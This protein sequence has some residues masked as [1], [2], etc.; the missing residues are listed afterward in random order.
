MDYKEEIAMALKKATGLGLDF[1][2]LIEVPP[3]SAMGDYA[4][5][6]F[7]LAKELKKAPQ[8]V[9]A[10][11][12]AKMKESW[13]EKAEAK[14]P[15]LNFFIQK[16][17]LFE[18]VLSRI[19]TLKD[20]YGSSQEG[21]GKNALV[22]HTSINPN[23][24]PHVGRARNALI[25]DSIVRILRFQGYKTEVHYFV[26]DVGKQI[27]MLVY[28]AGK[29]KV[30]FDGLLQLYVDVNNKV[31]A[32]PGL[33]KK[34]FALLNK[35]ETG[36]KAVKQKFKAIVG[37]CIKGQ[38]KILGE[39][40]IK[41]D[42]F[43][44]ESKY[45]WNKRTEEVLAL[46]RAKGK[47]SEDEAGRLVLNQEEYNLPTKA[48]F[49]VLTRADKTSLY[50]LRDIAY[51]ID[52]AAKAKG[53]NIVVLGED[54]KLYFQQID[55]A[56]ALLGFRAPEAVH[57][58]FVLLS[59]GKMS[60]RQGNVILLEDFM[61]EAVEKANE[62]IKKRR[63]TSDLKTAKIVAY[64]AV[65]YAIL[66]VSNEKNVLF[67]WDSAL[68]FE[69][70]TGPYIQYTY[71]RARSILRKAKKMPSRADYCLLTA[72]SEKR[73]ISALAS[74]PDAVKEA[75]DHYRP[76]VVAKHLLDI[77]QA[78]N[79]FYHS[80]QCLSDCVDPKLRD[81]RLMLVSSASLALKNGLFLIGISAPEKM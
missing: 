21:R 81:A 7:S 20:K 48:P 38:A 42:S 12:Q 72:D 24:S 47:L 33:E 60:T 28:G 46:L 36:D 54:Q 41:Y 11:L 65:K 63:G 62:E 15:Y 43:D 26:N 35:L 78:F 67:D 34:V 32:N 59:D 5:P 14:G 69:G 45:L 52:K 74:F 50:P 51:T 27:A 4:L 71:A 22:E 73:L 19:Q 61:K 70:E 16:S 13:I 75:A 31:K 80:C 64:G 53:K 56:L 1:L 39:L 10:E 29:K 40:G 55:A 77:S 37:T 2:Q 79:E 58:S 25:G 17:C 66:K 68:N 76:S 6:C 57:Y 30:S 23:A 8:A 49:L 44:Y 9:A 3:D 18:D